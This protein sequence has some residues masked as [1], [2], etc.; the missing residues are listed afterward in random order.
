MGGEGKPSGAKII[1]PAMPPDDLSTVDHIGC[2]RCPAEIGPVTGG[3]ERFKKCATLEFL[4]AVVGGHVPVIIFKGR[5]ERVIGALIKLADPE[6]FLFWRWPF[7]GGAG[8]AGADKQQ[9]CGKKRWNFF[10]R[11]I[12]LLNQAANV[13][14]A[15]ESMV[16]AAGKFFH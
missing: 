12:I 1:H 9:G 3:G 13:G 2:P 5:G 4:P 7:G 8:D 11:H 15:V 14:F 16:A 6:G 10:N